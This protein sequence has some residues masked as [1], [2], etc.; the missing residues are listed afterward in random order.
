MSPSAIAAW[1]SRRSNFVKRYFEEEEMVKTKAMEAGTMIHRLIE[2][3]MMEAKCR[4]DETEKELRVHLTDDVD[5]MGYPD[6]HTSEAKD[7]VA[8]FVDYKSGKANHWE[9]KLPTD[10]KMRATAWLV[11][12]ETGEPDEVV[13][14]VEYIPTTWNPEAEEVQPI[15]GAES[16]VVSYTYTAS[17]LEGFTDV[18]MKSIEDVNEFYEKWQESSD[19]FV[20]ESD[21]KE[22]ENL[23]AKKDEFVEDIDTKIDDVQ[24][25]IESQMKFGGITTYRG[26]GGTYS[27]RSYESYDHPDELTVHYDGEELTL[28]EAKKRKKGLKDAIK[29]AKKNYERITEPESVKESISF[30]RKKD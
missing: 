27:L 16:E 12:K 21:V 24:S 25:R 6:S 20:E 2:G 22:Y 11:W 30:Y 29:V 26:E 1:H 5:F 15:E 19:Q 7:S 23:R 3:G 8:K 13:G 18:I 17:E 14:Q 4:Y 28:K 9:D 10:M